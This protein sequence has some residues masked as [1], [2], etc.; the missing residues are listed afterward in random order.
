MYWHTYIKWGFRG[1]FK[2]DDKTIKFNRA[3]RASERVGWQ[4]GYNLAFIV[5]VVTSIHQAF[6]AS[7]SQTNYLSSRHG[8]AVFLL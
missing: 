7:D 4:T 6:F 8:C 3:R 1:W 5:L 2:R